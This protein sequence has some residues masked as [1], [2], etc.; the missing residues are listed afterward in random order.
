MVKEKMKLDMQKVWKIFWILAIAVI[1]ANV[2]DT[3]TT[4]M[5]LHSGFM[6]EANPFFRFFINKFGA[7]AYPIKLLLV[8]YVVLPMKKCPL[9]YCIN[10]N[11]NSIG[12]LT[13]LVSILSFIGLM[14]LFF[15]I[16][17]LVWLVLLALL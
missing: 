8:T 4:Y 16:L 5:A 12:A 6:H 15:G 11:A 13:V 2:L 17:N 10:A 9:Y 3:I 1:A 14:F 7:F